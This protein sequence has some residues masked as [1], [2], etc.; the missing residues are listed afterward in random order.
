MKAFVDA[1]EE[2]TGQTCEVKKVVP[3]VYQIECHRD[4]KGVLSI[5]FYL[6]DAGERIPSQD[7]MLH[8]D[9]DLWATQPHKLL[10]RLKVR[11]GMGKKIHARETVV[12][13][14]D[15]KQA[16]SF[17][18]DHHL[19]VALPGK[20]RYGLFLRGELV[21]VAVF[22]GGRKMRDLPADYRSYELLR[23]CH[24][25]KMLIVGGL[26][27]LLK[28][29]EEEHH[30]GNLM[31]YLDRDWSD[32]RSYEQLGF[33]VRG[34]TA[35]QQFWIDRHTLQR[36]TAY[37]RPEEGDFYRLRNQ[38]SLKLV[39]SWVNHPAPIVILGPT[40]SG[41]T[42]L[43]VQLARRIGGAIISADSRQVYRGLDIGTGK[44]LDEY[45]E[46]P[47][48]L[49]D[50]VEAGEQYH[51]AN[52]LTDAAEAL[53]E[54][55]QLGLIPIICG[56]TGMYI[57]GLV[58]GYPYSDVPRNEPLRASLAK[59]TLEELRAK[60]MKLPIPKDFQPDTSTSKRVIRAI[61]IVEWLQEHPNFR[62]RPAQ[63]PDAKVYGLAP[64]R[65]S[66][67]QAISRRLLDRLEQGLLDEVQGLLERGLTPDQL[68]RY[69]L[70]YK[71]CTLYLLGQL[72]SYEAF[73]ARL[74]AEIHRFAKRQMTYFRK[75]EKDGIQIQWLD[76][77]DPKIWDNVTG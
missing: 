32:G 74:E 62:A 5:L 53:R 9:E 47:Y 46:I 31:T 11:M 28:Q 56:G 40:A 65:E 6:R 54:I 68:I 12:A 57:Q 75:M 45:G 29:F 43:A 49:I 33:E 51:V 8:I 2:I 63:C 25:G 16:M 72:G 38:G 41:K 48:Y 34:V 66:R 18:K 37:D 3:S 22:S 44:D 20:F 39:K 1:L 19:Q 76:A 50:I 30:P 26:M 67:R 69:G 27:K 61:E 55:R 7:G 73:V 21:S 58:Q 42:R 59:F 36:Y 10:A 15:K 64:D 17:Q 77:A 4:G 52:F 71:Y 35:P 24:K 13:R 60:L 14:I 23:F 70:E